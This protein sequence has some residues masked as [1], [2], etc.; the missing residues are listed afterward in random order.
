MNNNNVWFLGPRQTGN[1]NMGDSKLRRTYSENMANWAHV[2]DGPNNVQ[3]IPPPMEF[4]EPTMYNNNSR[5]SSYYH[6]DQMYQPSHEDPWVYRGP[7]EIPR[8]SMEQNLGRSGAAEISRSN[9]L[10]S[11]RRPLS[12][13]SDDRYDMRNIPRDTDV[14]NRGLRRVS[15]MS[16]PH[17]FQN[18]PQSS[19]DYLPQNNSPNQFVSGGRGQPYVNMPGNRH[20]VCVLPSDSRSPT[21]GYTTDLDQRY[22]LSGSSYDLRHPQPCYYQKPEADSTNNAKYL[23]VPPQKKK[24]HRRSQSQGQMQQQYGQRMQG[25][26]P[27]PPST[28]IGRKW[29]YLY[30]SEKEGG[31]K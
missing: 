5:P 7:P 17:P 13:V 6:G 14:R 2:Y 26:A 30:W 11:R 8:K 10:Y 22:N 19:D 4:A 28:D 9:S 24:G 18:R 3:T 25:M 1:G 27:S 15:S 31:V 21:V 16:I 23:Q 20:S 29:C 12:N